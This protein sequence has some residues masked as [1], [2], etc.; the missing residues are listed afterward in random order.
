MPSPLEYVDKLI[1]IV[2]A[3]Q[4]KSGSNVPRLDFHTLIKTWFAYWG[5]EINRLQTAGSNGAFYRRRVFRLQ[6]FKDA[7]LD[8]GSGYPPPFLKG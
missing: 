3:V 1:R 7:V 2:R 8:L 6:T 5:G 4:H